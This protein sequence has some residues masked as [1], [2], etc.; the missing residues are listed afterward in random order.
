[1]F[2]RPQSDVEIALLDKP[3]V[4]QLPFIFGMD[5]AELFAAPKTLAKGQ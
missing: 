2:P 5:E 4:A 1:M 3:G